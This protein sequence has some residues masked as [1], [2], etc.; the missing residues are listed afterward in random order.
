MGE[1]G[2]SKMSYPPDDA[3]CTLLLLPRHNLQAIAAWRDG[4]GYS[5]SQ[6]VSQYFMAIEGF[7]KPEIITKVP[8][9]GSDQARTW[10]K[11]A[12]QSHRQQ[13]YFLLKPMTK[14]CSAS[15]SLHLG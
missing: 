6:L 13:R 8:E 1:E 7:T 4:T 12:R 9:A 10:E 14:S 2:H 3:L 15:A 5:R 11:A